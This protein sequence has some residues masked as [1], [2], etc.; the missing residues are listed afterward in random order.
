MA[1]H[2]HAAG[3]LHSKAVCSAYGIFDFIKRKVPSANEGV[4]R[5]HSPIV[6]WFWV[7]LSREVFLLFVHRVLLIHKRVKL[8]LDTVC[9][10][11]DILKW[12]SCQKA[13]KALFA[14]E[15]ESNLHVK[16]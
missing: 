2:K 3:P 11:A 9:L 7:E 14:I 6:F 5:A 16:A 13:S 12:N 10:Q 8:A 15:Y 4:F 1:V